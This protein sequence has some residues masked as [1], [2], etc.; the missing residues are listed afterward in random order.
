MKS[1][2]MIKFQTIYSACGLEIVCGAACRRLDEQFN[3]S[4]S[5]IE[6]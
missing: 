6:K 1:T 5:E 3:P 2:N 4:L